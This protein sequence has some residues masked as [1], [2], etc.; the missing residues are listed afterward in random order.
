MSKTLSPI[1]LHPKTSQVGFRFALEGGLKESIKFFIEHNA[2]RPDLIFYELVK[3]MLQHGVE[4]TLSL[5]KDCGQSEKFLEDLIRKVSN[6]YTY[7]LVINMRTALRMM[8]KAQ[9]CKVLLQKMYRTALKA[10]DHDIVEVLIAHASTAMHDSKDLRIASAMGLEWTVDMLLWDKRSNP[11]ARNSEAIR[12]AADNGHY[13]VFMMLLEDGRVNPKVAITSFKALR[14]K[15]GLEKITNL[16]E[17]DWVRSPRLINNPIFADALNRFNIELEE[18]QNTLLGKE[19]PTLN[20]TKANIQIQKAEPLAILSTEKPDAAQPKPAID[21][22]TTTKSEELNKELINAAKRGLYAEVARLLADERVDPFANK[23]EAIKRAASNSH[24]KVVMMLMQDGRVVPEIAAKAF[25]V[26]ANKLGL[27]KIAGLMNEDWERNPKL[28]NNPIF[29]VALDRFNTEL[30]EK[31][32]TFLGKELLSLNQ[33]NL[34]MADPDSLIQEPKEVK[35]VHSKPALKISEAKITEPKDLIK[36]LCDAAENGLQT[37]VK[38]LLEDEHVD[39]SSNENEALKKAAANGHYEVVRMLILDP[40]ID[41]ETAK[42]AIMTVKSKIGLHEITRLMYDD[43]V[44]YHSLNYH[45]AFGTS[46]TE[47]L[48]ELDERSM[49]F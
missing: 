40:R 14:D 13:K 24:Y 16:M 5:L 25:A 9:D 18:L 21:I 20:D 34:V 30:E 17:E 19:V 8:D 3:N 22:S 2:E 28:I 37:E 27:E 29:K 23:N 43:L 1:A 6:L 38:R 26:L 44:I 46:L 39:P 33:K 31:Q 11:A 36:E 10:N 7:A 12:K 32:N 47:F 15:L 45:H 49:A 42:I 35:V 4:H 41:Q 48:A